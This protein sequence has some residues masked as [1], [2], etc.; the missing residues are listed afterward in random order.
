[1][2]SLRGFKA[3]YLVAQDAVRVVNRHGCA[4]LQALKGKT[5]S[6]AGQ[7]LRA[8]WTRTQSGAGDSCR[9]RPRGHDGGG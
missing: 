6:G 4:S 1:M 9:I 3:L 2:H 8:V 7:P 5:L